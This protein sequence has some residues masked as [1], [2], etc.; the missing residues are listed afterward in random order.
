MIVSGAHMFL[1]EV[2]VSI[3]KVGFMLSTCNDLPIHLDDLDHRILLELM[4]QPVIPFAQVANTVGTSTATVATRYRRMFRHGLV[5][6]C[7]RTA[8]GFGGRRAYL[9]RAMAAPERVA[10]LATIVAAHSNSRW[11]RISLDGSTLICGLVTDSPGTDPVL[12]HLPAEANVRTV[13]ISELLHVWG[14]HTA[15]P[16]HPDIDTLDEALL[17]KLAVDGRSTVSALA[18]G[19]GVNAS[20]VSRRRQ[21][22]IDAGVL[23]FE[24]DI[25][26]QALVG[27][28]DAM[29]WLRMTPGHIRT[30][31]ETL[32]MDQ[33]VRFIAATTGT[34]SL[35]LHVHVLDNSE[36]LDFIDTTL[37]GLGVTSADVV[38]LG[39]VLKRNAV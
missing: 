35:V 21:R 12:T 26:P 27:S 31:G 30:T 9:M 19:L 13:D 7:G 2:G 39:R 38:P 22:L 33:R 20:T 17:A 36:L 8:P 10:R 4:R 18:A 29:V 37:A 5:R 6:V 24:A 23:Y 34:H 14:G 11:V 32:W 25:H 15:H 28:G 1:E 16:G 3:C